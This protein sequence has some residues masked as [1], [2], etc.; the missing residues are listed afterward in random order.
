MSSRKKFK[1][2]AQAVRHPVN[3]RNQLEEPVSPQLSECR[4]LLFAGGGIVAT[5]AFYP[6]YFPWHILAV[7]GSL[8]I[9][10][11]FVM[12]CIA[13]TAGNDSSIKYQK[14]RLES[15]K[16]ELD[17]IAATKKACTVSDAQ[18]D[19]DHEAAVLQIQ[20]ELDQLL[21]RQ[22]RLLAG[23][24][25]MSQAQE[26]RRAR[27]IAMADERRQGLLRMQ[28]FELEQVSAL[29]K[30]KIADLESELKEL[31]DNQ[32]AELHAELS[33]LQAK[34]RQEFLQGYLI[35]H[36]PIIGITEETRTT[37]T[38]M[39]ICSAFDISAD[40]T[41]SIRIFRAKSKTTACLARL[42]LSASR[43]QKTCLVERP[44]SEEDKEQV[45]Q[46]TYEN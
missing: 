29:Y 14:D 23:E 17:K 20:Y 24:R 2:A 42:S 11:V 32:A 36:S 5:S 41:G 45:W 6:L 15:L 18:A 27:M 3:L 22:S 8:V 43:N 12:F 46:T 10:M 4:K 39:G 25:Q 44:A 33:A 34:S 30:E 9:F 1:R 37:L 19:V 16:G 40:R 13:V 21:V 7:A 26:M 38:S 31:D 35:K 28:E